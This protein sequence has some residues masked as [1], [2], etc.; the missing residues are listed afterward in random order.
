VALRGSAQQA[1]PLLRAGQYAFYGFCALVFL[2]LVLP[3]LAVVP[4]SFNSGS[5]LTYPL[6]GLSLRWYR[7]FF[8]SAHWLPALRN[9]LL[10][11]C[12]STAIATPLGTLAALG[13]VRAHVGGKP[14]IFGFLIAP[15]IVPVIVTAIG[16]YFLYAPL[17][18]TNTYLGLILSHAVLG[19]PFVVVVVHATLQ[20]FDA[21]LWR[22]GTS[23]GASPARVF[24]RV[25]LPL[26]APGVAAGAVF[27]FTTSFDEIVTA[28]FLAGPEQRT[29]P[30]QMFDG[31]REQ[32]SPTVTA[33]ATL[34]TLVSV[35]LLATVELLRRRSQRLYGRRAVDG[36]GDRGDLRSASTS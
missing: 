18:L 3:I 26:I 21:N 22:A 6:A 34:L 35:L 25:V 23:L 16:A 33:A 13:L 19:A 28:I 24:V 1:S 27:A 17:G 15:M 29:L 5:F 32:I 2:F 4:L 36:P 7:D 31:V 10:V 8:T 11:A 9:S 30:L 12:A 14:L 20:G